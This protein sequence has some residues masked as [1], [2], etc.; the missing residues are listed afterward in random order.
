MT[1]MSMIAGGKKNNI[2]NIFNYVISTKD[3]E[4]LILPVAQF[5]SNGNTLTI[6]NQHT[7]VQIV[8]NEYDKQ[9]EMFKVLL[10]GGTTITLLPFCGT[11]IVVSLVKNTYVDEIIIAG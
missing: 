5:K 10:H 6:I 9:N 8:A 11:W 4:E 2:S 7:D 3:N 1:M